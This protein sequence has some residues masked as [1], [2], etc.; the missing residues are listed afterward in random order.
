M[1]I[2]ILFKLENKVGEASPNKTTPAPKMGFHPL[3]GKNYISICA[4]YCLHY[5][6]DILGSLSSDS[7]ELKRSTKFSFVKRD[8]RKEAVLLT[9][10]TVCWLL[11]LNTTDEES[12]SVV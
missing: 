1:N 12:T 6:E 7:T 11:L 8:K 4:T 5:K 10:T 3:R 9:N 2:K